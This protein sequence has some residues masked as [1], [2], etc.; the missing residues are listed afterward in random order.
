M[1]FPV[2]RNFGQVIQEG[3]SPYHLEYETRLTDRSRSRLEGG[4]L[5]I[6]P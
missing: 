3:E 1:T 5:E 6:S 4:I 2:H